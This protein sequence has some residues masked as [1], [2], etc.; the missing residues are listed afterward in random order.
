M[1]KGFADKDFSGKDI[2]G[3][4]SGR[5]DETGKDLAG[6]DKVQQGASRGF[7]TYTQNFSTMMKDMRYIVT[8]FIRY[9][10]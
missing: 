6:M 4:V 7:P 5:K 2:T 10:D 1:S 8:R 9:M 3:K